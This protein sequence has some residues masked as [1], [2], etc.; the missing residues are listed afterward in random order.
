MLLSF[1]YFASILGMALNHTLP[2]SKG[3]LSGNKTRGHNLQREGTES[4][5]NRARS[6]MLETNWSTIEPVSSETL[7]SSHQE[8]QQ[9]DELDHNVE[10]GSNNCN[11]VFVQDCLHR[12]QT[13][14]FHQHHQHHEVHNDSVKT[15]IE[16]NSHSFLRPD[17]S[18]NIQYST[19]SANN[20]YFRNASGDDDEPLLRDGSETLRTKSPSSNVDPRIIVI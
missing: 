2:S 4:T 16:S 14:R 15:E 17:Q 9:Q 3:S 10:T 8:R 7:I 11:G 6:N 20:G 13:M 18:H 12:Q 19:G 1:C 5:A